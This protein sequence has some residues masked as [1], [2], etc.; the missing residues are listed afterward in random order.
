MT[1]L[2]M[3]DKDCEYGWAD[4]KPARHPI[5]IMKTLALSAWKLASKM[6]DDCRD[7]DEIKEM[8]EIAT[9]LDKLANDDCTCTPRQECRVCNL[10]AKLI[11]NEDYIEWRRNE[12]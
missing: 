7:W 9:E 5:N 10:T 3:T 4:I 1:W 2:N 12:K 8:Q 11:Y 6:V